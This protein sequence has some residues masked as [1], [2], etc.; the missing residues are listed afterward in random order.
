VGPFTLVSPGLG[1]EVASERP[2][3]EGREVFTVGGYVEVVGVGKGADCICGVTFALVGL[4]RL[5]GWPF[6]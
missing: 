3:S 2:A 1:F 4:R 5:L 6:E